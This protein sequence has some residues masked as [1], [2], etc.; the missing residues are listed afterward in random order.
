MA[1]ATLPRRTSGARS[2]TI[3]ARRG[4]GNL[5]VLYAQ[6]DDLKRAESFLRLAADVS[7]EKPEALRNLALAL[8]GSGRYDDAMGILQRALQRAP[9]N[10]DV[11]L[12]IGAIQQQNRQIGQAVH[13][14]RK[15][16]EYALASSPAH[17][18][19]ANACLA[20]SDGSC[21]LDVAS[22][23]VR[24]APDSALAHAERAAALC[25]LHQIQGAAESKVALR[26]DPSIGNVGAEECLR[27]DGAE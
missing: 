4:R 9:E 25:V 19:L 26:L 14:L 18:V 17:S 11:R 3:G 10:G 21:A 5:G 6:T 22:E 8:S 23:A 24:L 13:S 12:A 15:A 1:D 20:A 16:V 7:P 2:Q 27:R